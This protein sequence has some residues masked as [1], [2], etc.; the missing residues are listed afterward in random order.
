M[1][2][3]PPES[4]KRQLYE[5]AHRVKDIEPWEWM[6]E[7]DI[8]GIQSPETGEYGFVSVMGMAGEHYAVSVYKGVA[9]IY[10]LFDFVMEDPELADPMDLMHIPQFQLSFE[11]R[12][13]LSSIDRNEIKALGYKYR[14][15]RAWVQ[16]R[17]YRPG[18][19]PWYLEADEAQFLLYGL[20]QL[21]DIAPRFEADE[22]LLTPEEEHQ[23]L[24]RV[25]RKDGAGLAW[26]DKKVAIPPPPEAPLRLPAQ[27]PALQQVQK[28]K[29][30][31]NRMEMDVFP[32]HTP[33]KEEK[34]ERPYYGYVFMLVDHESGMIVHND[35]LQPFPSYEAMQA[36]IPDLLIAAL[37]RLKI[38]PAEIGVARKWLDTMLRPVAKAAGLEVTL[39]DFVPTI[40]M[41]RE[42]LYQRF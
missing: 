5:T 30:N 3:P 32:L 31:R 14:G 28:L 37:A 36:K 40:A 20:E 27:S 29:K 35:M 17:C 25:P 26:E 39:L 42:S 21:L 33:I 22:D 19:A 16:F 4:L 12:N 18:Y 6:E 34:D 10:Q 24:V 1:V 15:S 23:F 11:D 8:F 9:A 13:M 7:S 2:T 41:I 38:H